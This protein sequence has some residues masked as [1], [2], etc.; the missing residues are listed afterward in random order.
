MSKTLRARIDDAVVDL[1]TKSVPPS[2]MR[3]GASQYTQSGYGGRIPTQYMV[4]MPGSQRW[5][6]VFC[7]IYS[8]S[9]TC[10]VDGPRLNGRK[11]RIIITD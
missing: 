4:Q 5:R 7:M 10:Y 1:P 2:W 8:N 9:G 6:R 11:T 3:S